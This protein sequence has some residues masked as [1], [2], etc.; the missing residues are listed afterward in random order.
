VRSKGWFRSDCDSG[1]HAH[2]HD[3]SRGCYLDPATNDDCHA[4]L[5]ANRLRYSHADRYA[6]T[7]RHCHANTDCRCHTDTDRHRYADTDCH[8]D[9]DRHRYADIDAY[10]DCNRCADKDAY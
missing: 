4:C 10:V 5:D 9:A 2:L 8:T 7:D 6:D 1:A 3:A